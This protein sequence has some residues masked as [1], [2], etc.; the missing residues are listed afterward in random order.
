MPK[1]NAGK[2][3]VVGQKVLLLKLDPLI[4]EFL[5]NEEREQLLALV[6]QEMDVYE[7]CGEYVGIQKY[8]SE[9][10]GIVMHRFSVSGEDIQGL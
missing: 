4:Y 2:E 6:G 9:G 8:W 5:S 10:P 1:D 3:V 7:I